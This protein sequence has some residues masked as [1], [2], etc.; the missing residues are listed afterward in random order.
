MQFSTSSPYIIAYL[1]LYINLVNKLSLHNYYNLLLL[2]SFEFAIAST[3]PSLHC[4]CFYV[5]FSALLLLLHSLLCTAIASTFPSLNCYCFYAPFSALL[6][7]LHSLLCTALFFS[8]TV[9]NYIRNFIN[10]NFY[11]ENSWGGG[12]EKSFGGR[13]SQGSPPPP[14]LYETLC[15]CT[16]HH[17]STHTLHT[18]THTDYK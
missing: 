18:H 5:P 7:L 10:I 6:L 15:I 1:H 14:P 4:Y 11:C 3:P 16:T 12:G 2:I 9:M 8:I 13:V 17:T